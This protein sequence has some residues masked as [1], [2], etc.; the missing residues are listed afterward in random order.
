MTGKR[1]RVTITFDVPAEADL[2][3]LYDHLLYI[4]HTQPGWNVLLSG[5]GKH[6]DRV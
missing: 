4:R 5:E 1:K 2:R 6:A 3:N